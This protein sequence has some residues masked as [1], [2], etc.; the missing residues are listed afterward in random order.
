MLSG[1]HPEP[2]ASN[3]AVV[4]A[5]TTAVAG[6]CALLS[7]VAGLGSAGVVAI[8]TSMAALALVL[9]VVAVCFAALAVA[10]LIWALRGRP[11]FD[12]DL[13]VRRVRR[14]R[15]HQRRVAMLFGAVGAFALSLEL[16]AHLGDGRA[17]TWRTSLGV[18]WFAV[19][20]AVLRFSRRPEV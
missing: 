14:R 1:G 19:A 4:R 16:A 5:L 12:A 7:L 15:G 20:A 11:S 2:G 17:N 18:L 9:G 6:A 3:H 10:L 13:L 8:D